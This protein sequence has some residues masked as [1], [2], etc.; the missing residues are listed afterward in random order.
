M[1]STN[2]TG[3]DPRSGRG[4]SLVVH[5]GVIERIEDVPIG[6]DFYLCAGLVDLQVNGCCGFDVNSADLTIETVVGLT[7]AMLSRGVTCFVPT[8]I[9]ASEQSICHALKTIAEARHR[10]ARVAACVPFVH[11]EGPHISPLDGYRGAHPLAFVRPPSLAE[12]DRWQSS[13]GG[14]VGMVTI[15]PHFAESTSYIRGLVQRGVH[16]ALGH[17]HAS[18]EQIHEAVDAGATLSTHLGNGIAAEIHRHRNP[19]WAQLADDRLTASFITDGHHLPSDTLK[20]MLRVKGEER[21]ILVSDS[22]AVAGLPAGTYT[23]PV[24][25]EVEL[26]SDGRVCIPGTE[27]LAGSAAS[28]AECVSHIVQTLDLP[29]D[30]ALLLATRNPGRIVGGHGELVPG[31]RANVL[32]FRWGDGMQVEDVWLAGEQVYTRQLTQ[33]RPEVRL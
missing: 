4:V 5:A 25:G 12:F 1:N 33:R 2:I 24:G 19:I 11:V 10:S 16:V 6:G 17:T 31:A 8:I 13:A 28:L 26:R 9:T 29:L 32:R 21:T 27:L 30:K 18:P 22:V 7:D 14:A 23:T 3:R 15:S 20:V